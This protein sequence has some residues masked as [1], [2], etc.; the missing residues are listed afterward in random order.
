MDAAKLNILIAKTIKTKTSLSSLLICITSISKTDPDGA[1]AFMEALCAHNIYK[2]ALVTARLSGFMAQRCREIVCDTLHRHLQSGEVFTGSDLLAVLEL[3]DHELFRQVSS[4]LDEPTIAAFFSECTAPRACRLMQWCLKY[5][6]HE[7]RQLCGQAFCAFLNRY[8][9]SGDEALKELLPVLLE[10]NAVEVLSRLMDTLGLQRLKLLHKE[11]WF[12]E[13]D[14]MIVSGYDS[15][16]LWDAYFECLFRQNPGNE[17]L[18]SQ[19]LWQ[20][21][22]FCD[23]D[24]SDDEDADED[25]E[26]RM[27]EVASCFYLHAAIHLPMDHEIFSY[28]TLFNAPSSFSRKHTLRYQDATLPLWDQPEELAR[29]IDTTNICNPFRWQVL[30]E[31]RF[32]LFQD[33]QDNG[34]YIRLSSFFEKGIDCATILKL[35][36][37]TGLKTS[38]PMED[39]LYLSQRHDRLAQMLDT[40]KDMPFHGIIT[41]HKTGLMIVSP[42]AYHV[43]TLHSLRVPYYML[44]PSKDEKTDRKGQTVLYTITDFYNGRIQVE[45]YRSETHTLRTPEVGTWEDAVSQLKHWLTTPPSKNKPTAKS[46]QLP[47]QQ[48]PLSSLSVENNLDLLTQLIRKIPEKLPNFTHI[49]RYSKWNSMFLTQDLLLPAHLYLEFS[50]YRPLALTLFADLVSSGAECPIILDLYFSSIY[51]IILPLNQL[52]ELMEKEVFLKA[53]ENRLVYCRIRN[54]LDNQCRPANIVC[55]PISQLENPNNMRLPHVF[56]TIIRDYELTNGKVSRIMM[57]CQ[58]NPVLPLKER[59]ALFGYLAMNIHIGNL[60]RHSI[61]RLPTV[62]QYTSREMIFNLQCMEEAILL[63]R[64]SGPELTKLLRTMGR[65]NPLTFQISPQADACYLSKL[66]SQDRRQSVTNATISMILNASGLEAI[67][68]IYLNTSAKYYLHL[69]ELA[70]LVRQRR[71]E[72]AAGIS[73]LFENIP[74]QCACDKNGFLWLPCVAQSTVYVGA[75]YAG[76]YLSCALSPE[77]SG[78]TARVLSAET[79]DEIL[80]PILLC[81]LNGYHNHAAMEP[82]VLEGLIKSGVTDG[83]A[84]SIRKALRNPEALLRLA[85]RFISRQGSLALKGESK[86]V[87]MHEW[88]QRLRPILYAEECNVKTMKKQICAMIKECYSGVNAAE[89]ESAIAELTEGLLQRITDK[90]K[91]FT[92]LRDVFSTYSYYFRDNGL[93]HIWIDQ[94]GR[95]LGSDIAAAY[96]AEILQNSRYLRNL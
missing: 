79:S 86:I 80:N 68:D 67:R 47:I 52:M 6:N 91:V 16:E 30:Q 49:F 51:K 35:F 96:K 84:E 31:T 42:K 10:H 22:L 44:E 2:A 38:L 4:R 65:K 58:I 17:A 76:M 78:I 92:F 72:L 20:I 75:E 77:E 90:E 89:M 82:I 34:D 69:D 18:L 43:M 9:S 26:A 5:T 83:G 21:Q 8:D 63:R 62:D 61:S 81:L 53:A 7:A 3:D 59:G 40:L 39:L 33:T 73:N 41:K 56:P 29:F 45:A 23:S 93:V 85:S 36:L 95:Y 24:D 66:Y 15:P 32:T 13:L 94:L 64:S 70:D 55:S 27:G 74:F 1:C 14:R 37:N 46:R 12:G 71:P 28:T 50:R 11:D 87:L 88:L 57:A 25:K 48:F 19:G 60:K 54:D